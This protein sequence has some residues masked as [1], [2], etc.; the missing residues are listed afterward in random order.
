MKNK[1]REELNWPSLR[2][3]S[4]YS[5]WKRVWVILKNP[6]TYIFYGYVEY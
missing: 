4:P 3:E 5:F 2:I 1:L 6:F